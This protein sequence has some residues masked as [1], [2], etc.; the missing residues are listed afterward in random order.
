[1]A[2]KKK[3]DWYTLDNAGI[4][5]SALQR[6]EYSAVY[7]FSAVLTEA[8]DPAALQRAVDECVPRFPGFSVRIKRGAFW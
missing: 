2:R 5:Y 6:E 8:V 3:P 7:R 4:L 1:M